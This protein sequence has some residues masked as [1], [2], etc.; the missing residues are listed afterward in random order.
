MDVRP[1]R[2]VGRPS[3]TTEAPRRGEWRRQ[4][5]ISA[6]R[7][8]GPTNQV[9]DRVGRWAACRAVTEQ[10]AR[11]EGHIA[12]LGRPFDRR[13]RMDPEVCRAAR[14]ADAPAWLRLRRLV[15]EYLY[16]KCT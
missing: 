3:D 12:I 8:A 13:P 15:C 10:V 6:I 2:L 7:S 16:L 1:S 5:V 11:I 14:T 9:D 4:R